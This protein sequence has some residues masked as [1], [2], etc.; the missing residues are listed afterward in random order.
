MRPLV[1]A[2]LF[3]TSF[4]PGAV[5]AQSTGLDPAFTFTVPPSRVVVRIPDTSL[6]PSAEPSN[7]PN[8][9]KLERHDPQLIVS[10][11]LEPV[12]GYK[13]LDAF[14]Q[15]ESSSPAFA[16]PLAPTRVEMLHE[17]RWEVV[18]YDVALPGGGT[19]S[20]LRA[21]QVAAGTWIDLHF[22]TVSTRPAATLRAELL[23]ALKGVQI[24]EKI[25]TRLPIRLQQ[26]KP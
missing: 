21:K 16:G 23:A 17:G 22:S 19:Q 1:A 14:W 9:F 6:R 4:A 15:S 18:A 7:G 13:G 25:V 10:G 24:W 2:V 8:Y 3:A 26:E 5:R 20:N 11:W 12:A